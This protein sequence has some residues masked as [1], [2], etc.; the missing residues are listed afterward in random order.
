MWETY[1]SKSF[2]VHPWPKKIFH[3]KDVLANFPSEMLMLNRQATA[4]G[5]SHIQ[6][7]AICNGVQALHP[8][9]SQ[10]PSNSILAPF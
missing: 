1:A 8:Q 2:G 10:T 3:V 6:G 9:V 5:Q 4:E 7:I